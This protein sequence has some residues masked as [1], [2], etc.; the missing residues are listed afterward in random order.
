MPSLSPRVD[1]ATWDPEDPER[2][3]SRFAWRTLWITT[4]NLT[5]AFIAWFNAGV[6][7]LDIRNPYQPREVG[8]FIPT[9]TDRTAERCIE[10]EGRQRCKRAI[11]TNVLNRNH[12]MDRGQSTV[13][14]TVAMLLAASLCATQAAAAED[15]SGEATEEV[16]L[17]AVV[18]TWAGKRPWTES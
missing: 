9:I 4:Y 11:Q 18:V 12:A 10:V 17:S 15:Q 2:W 14:A 8:Y 1:L 6:R 16:E 3:D 13:A 5:L 7:A